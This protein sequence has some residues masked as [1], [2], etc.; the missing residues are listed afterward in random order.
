MGTSEHRDDGCSCNPALRVVPLPPVRRA[1]ATVGGAMAGPRGSAPRSAT[2]G[3]ATC[4]PVPPTTSEINFA[5]DSSSTPMVRAIVGHHV[6]G[7][8]P[9]ARLDAFLQALGRQSRVRIDWRGDQP[10]YGLPIDPRRTGRC[11]GTCDGPKIQMN[12]PCVTGSLTKDEADR[13]ALDWPSVTIEQF[14]LD[15]PAGYAKLLA[16]AEAALW[17]DAS[18]I[19]R[20]EDRSCE[21]AGIGVLIGDPVPLAVRVSRTSWC[22]RFAFDCRLQGTCFDQGGA[23]H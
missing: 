9:R 16:A 21:C 4:S 8:G 12:G 23:T 11:R 13:A 19:P 1:G 15:N 7:E 10:P 18:N 17:G 22:V 20:C 6:H 5:A 3:S 2:C 14:K